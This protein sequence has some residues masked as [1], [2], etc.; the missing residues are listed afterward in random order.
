MTCAILWTCIV[1]VDDDVVVAVV[2]V[3]NIY[4][5]RLIILHNCKYNVNN[6]NNNSNNII[7]NNNNN[8]NNSK[9]EFLLPISSPSTER[10]TTLIQDITNMKAQTDI[11]Q[12]ESLNQ[13]WPKTCKNTRICGQN[14]PC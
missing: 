12:N 10:N 8:N 6:N 9:S 2:V 4:I 14:V 13:D 7:I 11:V 1:V 3:K 5:Y